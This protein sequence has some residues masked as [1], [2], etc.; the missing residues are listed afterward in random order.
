MS[1]YFIGAILQ[2]LSSPN[3][4]VTG[5]NF[6]ATLTKIDECMEFIKAHVR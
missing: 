1:E 2:K 4:Q 5:E 6:L 3:L